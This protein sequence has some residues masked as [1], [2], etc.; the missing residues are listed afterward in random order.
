MDMALNTA[1]SRKSRQL[2]HAIPVELV[3][4]FFIAEPTCR[5]SMHPLFG[6]LAATEH[7][8]ADCCAVRRKQ[9]TFELLPSFLAGAYRVS[10]RGECKH[11]SQ[12]GRLRSATSPTAGKGITWLFDG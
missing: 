11:L 10:S 12:Q 7:T 2:D 1:G 8:L 5:T 9:D 6:H 3:S 4:F